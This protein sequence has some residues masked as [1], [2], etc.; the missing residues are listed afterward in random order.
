MSS[1]SYF[2]DTPAG[3][4]PY[5]A[6]Q[7]EQRRQ[8]EA[9]WQAGRKP[10]AE[11]EARAERDKRLTLCDW[12]ACSD[13]VL[14]QAWAAYRQQLRDVPQQEGFPDVIVWPEVPS[15]AA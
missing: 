6:E 14:S 8:E 5:T 10:R 1:H 3:R 13:L 15:N 11:A 2:F 4:I 7:E 9:A 12:R